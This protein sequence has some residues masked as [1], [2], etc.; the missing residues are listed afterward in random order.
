MQT[1]IAISSY[2]L[3]YSINVNVKNKEVYDKE[4]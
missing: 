2:Q 1:F 3:T 4:T